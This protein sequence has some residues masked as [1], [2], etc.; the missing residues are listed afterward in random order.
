MLAFQTPGMKFTQLSGC[1]IATAAY[2]SAEEHSV[3]ALRRV[4][5]RLRRA[6]TLFAT[7]TELYYRSGPAAAEVLRRSDTARAL[8]RRLLRPVGEAAEALAPEN[9]R[10]RSPGTPR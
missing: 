4:R 10:T 2:G 6:S 9:R 3:A 5:D 8:V 7:A 1:F